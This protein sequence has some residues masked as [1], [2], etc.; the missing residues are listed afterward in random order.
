MRYAVFVSIDC[1]ASASS[2]DEYSITWVGDDSYVK[3]SESYVVQTLG[4][5]SHVATTLRVFTTNKKNCYSI[6][7]DEGDRVLARATFNYGNYDK[8]SSPPSFDL[9]FNGNLWGNVEGN[10]YAVFY[11]TIYTVKGDSVSICVTQAYPDQFPFI[12]A[13]EVRSL[14]T[15]MYRHIDPN[16][17]L[18]LFGRNAFGT[19][20]T[21]RFPDDTYDR[22]WRNT[23]MVKGVNKVKSDTSMITVDVED[24]PP[25]SV[26]QSGI[27]SANLSTYITLLP[28][29]ATVEI[30]IYINTYFSEV[31]KLNLTQKRSFG[32]YINYNLTTT[33]PIIPPYKS[34]L[35][36]VTTGI[37]TSASNQ[38]VLIPSN[39]SILPPLINAMEAFHVGN[40]LTDGTNAKDVFISI[41]CG[42]SSSH[43][44][45]NLITWV[46]DDP[47]VKTGENRAIQT[48]DYDKSNYFGQISRVLSTVRVFPKNK[49]NCYSITVLEGDRVLVRA[50]FAYG[51]YDG[52]S[53]PPNF[54]LSFNG[55]LWDNVV[56]NIA[57]WF[58]YEAIYTVKGDTVSVCLT[59]TNPNQFPFINGLEV[60]SLDKSMYKHVDLD[61]PLFLKSRYSFGANETVRFPDDA[62]DRIWMKTMVGG[63]NKVQSD[64]SLTTVDAEDHP[65]KSILQ[66]GVVSSNLTTLIILY[67]NLEKVEG[68][69][70]INTYFSEVSKLNLTQKRSFYM[71]MN[72]NSTTTSPIIPPYQSVLE[73]VTTG[74]NASSS[75]PFL[76][77]P[78]ND[79]TLPPLI[80]AM[81]AFQVGGKLTDGTSAKDVAALTLLQKS[82]EQLQES[83]GDPCLPSPDTWDWVACNSDPRPR[84]TALYLNGLGLSG[85]LPDFSTLDA[86]QKIYLQNNNFT[87]EVPD[88]LG[89][90]PKLI[91]LNLANNKF[92]GS[93]PVS[94]SQRK[95][96]K[97]K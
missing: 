43:T 27:V 62:Y 51:N 35:E 83:S 52:K 7:V 55:N 59:Q 89:S 4:Q 41:D 80:N 79:S 34:V 78:S 8:K 21:L 69:A 10:N 77:I 56:S 45:G 11:E 18:F 58:Y 66:S 90:F 17:P 74:I 24:H 20:Q 76:L 40:E 12:S 32:I 70:Y 54:D 94:I 75:T 1:G 96:L 88:F 38:L 53:S 46:K 84:V 14:N 49:K 6:K 39:D 31:S 30:S 48:L 87:E 42:A 93:I 44:D 19:N 9:L 37:N 86:L 92:S 26:I 82:F 61:Y 60:R 85:T 5:V 57:D 36:M 28:T 63:L 23:S 67:P 25:K 33:S 68:P 95:D 91:E 16:Y 47:Y 13:L 71:Y 50:T 72:Y 73:M 22:I 29:L 65:P 3:S 97:L 15:S 2:I 64:T 81:E